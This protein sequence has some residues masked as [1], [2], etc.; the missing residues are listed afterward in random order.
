MDWFG[1]PRYVGWVQRYAFT[2]VGWTFYASP[3]CT[4]T[5]FHDGLRCGAVYFIH[6]RLRTVLL[7]AI[8]HTPRGCSWTR[9]RT[10]DVRPDRLTSS[11]GSTTYAGHAYIA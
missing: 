8:T 5:L 1:V 10:V 2:A 9:H 4:Y 3:F 11:S 7:D 6:V